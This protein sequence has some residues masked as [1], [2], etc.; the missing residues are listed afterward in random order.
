MPKDINVTKCF[1]CSEMEKLIIRTEARLLD[2]LRT[3]LPSKEYWPRRRKLEE[4]A[5]KYS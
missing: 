3:S 1:H 2:E 4:N 5:K